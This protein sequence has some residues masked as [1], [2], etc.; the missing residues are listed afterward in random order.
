MNELPTAHAVEL[1]GCDDN[2]DGISE[3]FDTSGV[4][5]LITGNQ[6]GMELTY[7]DELGNQLPH[8]L[9]NPY[10]NTLPNRETITARVTNSQSGCFVETSLS[11]ITSVQPQIN[12]LA[13]LF[14]CDEGNGKASFNTTN[15]EKK[16]IG[17]QS[18]L[19]ISYFDTNGTA[20]PS[21]LP[22][23]FQNTTA[24]SQHIEVRVENA[25]NPLCYTETG[26]DLIV[27]LKPE[28][29]INEIYTICDLEP[30]L[31]LRYSDSFDSWKWQYE[32][33]SIVSTNSNITME[34]EGD[35]ILTIGKTK[36]GVRCINSY[37][38]E[39]KRSAPP[40]IEQVA[41]TD[42][43]NNNY[44]EIRASGDGEFEYSI[45]GINFQNSNLF[46]FIA[47]GIYNAT[48]RDKKGCGTDSREV[49]LMDYK[50]VFTPNGDGYND[51]WQIKGIKSFP[52]AKIRIYDRYGKF[53]KQI[54]AQSVGWVGTFN[55]KQ[56]PSTDYW[57]HVNLGN[58]RIYKNHFTLKR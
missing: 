35:Y 1:I 28:I 9:P 46:Q 27:N 56:M 10:I 29:E 36:N 41:F 43:S 34:Q 33:G 42:W 5:A 53:L 19:T 24:W 18:G 52:N 39:L 8:P 22:A 13:P 15:I 12:S 48:V 51:H 21:P 38:F 50:K 16:L 47:G 45:D 37:A 55:N 32:D 57:F 23:D 2:T 7:F 20:L 40:T 11:L 3:Y 31:E 17:N 14:A 49:V 6:V 30:S 44:I 25:N 54:T 4:K 26:F 58:N